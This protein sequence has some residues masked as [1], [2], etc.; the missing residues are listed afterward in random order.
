M[1]RTGEQQKSAAASRLPFIDFARGIAMVLM[2]WD[3]VSGFWNPGHQ[4]S[5]GL[6]GRRPV[7][8]NFTQFMLRFITHYCAPTFIFLAGT[9]LA[10][11]T[12]KR[13]SAGE[14]Q[15]NISLRMIKRGAALL[16]F[17]VFVESSAFGNSP[18][19]FGV[20]SCIGLCFIIF[21]VYHRLPSIAIL[22]VSVLIIVA[23]PFLNLGWI[24]NDNPGGWYL[25][26]IIHEPSFDRYPY[27]GLYPIIP[28]IG[29]MGLGW[30]FGNFLST[31]DTTRI[32]RLMAPL[33]AGGV[34][35]IGAWFVVRFF[36][37]YG[38]LLPRLGNTLEDWL[39]MSKYPPDLAFLLWTLG[40][41]CLFLAFGLLLQ[42]R[43]GFNRGVT[44]AILTFGTVPLFFYLTHLWLYRL[45]PGWMLRAPFQL[46]LAT[47]AAFWLVGLLI[48]WRLSIRYEKLKREHPNSLLQYI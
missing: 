36:N 39:Y 23:H 44:G 28:W 3:H 30:V 10:L 45:R 37:G 43:A 20:I 38:N 14:S 7:F 33:A 1:Q 25:R 41:T 4:G 11:S 27:D 31:Y 32:R 42:G 26:V 35:S 13:A 12:A 15:R 19:Y 48:L 46:D 5:E 34:A 17:G 22:V 47:T 21:S 2:A 29:V 24:P 18:F 6:M 40:G 16:L 9:S 8:Q